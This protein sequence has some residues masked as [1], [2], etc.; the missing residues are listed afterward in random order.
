VVA[1]LKRAVAS[2]RGPMPQQR[3]VVFGAGAAGLGGARQIRAQLAEEGLDEAERVA[4]I[5]VLDRHGLLVDDGRIMDPY[6]RE[7]AWP[8]ERAAECGLADRHARGLGDVVR[9]LRPKIGRA[10]CRDRGKSPA[11]T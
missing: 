6:K 8:A 7:L 9:A 2:R 4:R 5:A 1:G 3:I 11:E 10:S